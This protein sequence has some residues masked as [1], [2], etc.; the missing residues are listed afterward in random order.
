ML[1]SAR[2]RIAQQELLEYM[3]E[4][5]SHQFMGQSEGLS[6]PLLSSSHLTA[7]VGWADGCGHGSST[8]CDGVRV[9]NATPCVSGSLR[10]CLQGRMNVIEQ[11]DVE[12]RVL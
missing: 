1:S 6:S 9:L 10:Y 4:E 2:C 5:T 11:V 8:C 3:A 7:Q 12:Y